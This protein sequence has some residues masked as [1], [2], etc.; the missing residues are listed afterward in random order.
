MRLLCLPKDFQCLVYFFFGKFKILVFCMLFVNTLKRICRILSFISSCS[1]SCSYY[2][3]A[4]YRQTE[5]NAITWYN[6][7]TSYTSNTRYTFTTR[8]K[9][10]LGTLQNDTVLIRPIKALPLVL[11]DLLSKSLHWSY[12][13]FQSFHWSYQIRPIFSYL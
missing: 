7:T 3:S 6:A 8:Y 2:K 12:H 13:T 11:S 10:R 9:R 4:Q 1:C 5:Y